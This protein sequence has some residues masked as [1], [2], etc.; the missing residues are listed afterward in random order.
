MKKKTN[1]RKFISQAIKLSASNIK[2]GGGPFGAIVVRKGRIIGR[3]ANRVTSNLDPTAHAE[4]VAIRQACAK[5][6]NFDLSGCEI[7]TSCEPCPMCLAAIYWARIDHIYF[8]NTRK[9]AALVDFDDEFIYREIP[10]HHRQRKIT[11]SQIG[12]KEA[13]KVFKDWKNLESKTTY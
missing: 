5:I 9:D 6:K 11:M 4:I 2:N 1:H 10:K 7:Y 8:A 12:R 13:L 3:G